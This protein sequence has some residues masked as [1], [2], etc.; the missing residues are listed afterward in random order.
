[1][2]AGERTRAR[3]SLKYVGVFFSLVCI[4]VKYNEIEWRAATLNEIFLY[5]STVLGA[6]FIYHHHQVT[7]NRLFILTNGHRLHV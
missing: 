7:L 1:M 3:V 4:H 6:Y 2:R 5:M